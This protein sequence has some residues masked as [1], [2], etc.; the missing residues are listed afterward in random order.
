MP[1]DNERINEL[2]AFCE[3]D[4][5][6]QEIEENGC[7]SDATMEEHN[8]GATTL[9]SRKSILVKQEEEERRGRKK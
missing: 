7:L 9:G 4:A 6:M 3:S 2:I 8:I 1:I 5:V